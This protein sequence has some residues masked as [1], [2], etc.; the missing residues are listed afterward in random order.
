MK[1]LRKICVDE[2]DYLWKIK[3]F[4]AHLLITV[5]QSGNKVPWATLHYPWVSPALYFPYLNHDDATESSAKQKAV[6]PK[7]IRRLIQRQSQAQGAPS[8]A[9]TYAHASDEITLSTTDTNT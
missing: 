1:G 2:R 6:T 7:L 9:W 8:K 4:E 3:A 5:W